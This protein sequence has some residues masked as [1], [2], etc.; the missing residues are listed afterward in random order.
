MSY[1]IRRQRVAYSN[2]AVGGAA[3][4]ERVILGN[5]GTTE[6]TFE[7]LRTSEGTDG[8]IGGV[9]TEPTA[10]ARN[11]IIAMSGA[12]ARTTLEPREN[13]VSTQ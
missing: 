2:I 8:G 13:P 10:N 5:G 1:N 7:R 12:T 4:K 6:A 11:R 3:G 9:S